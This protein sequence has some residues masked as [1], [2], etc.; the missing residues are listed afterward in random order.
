MQHSELDRHH[1]SIF[2]NLPSLENQTNQVDIILKP[3]N[4]RDIYKFRFSA[5]VNA[6]LYTADEV[7]LGT[8]HPIIFE[9]IIVKQLKETFPK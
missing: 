1:I 5:T 7:K 4:R 9:R 2:K 3:F 6:H 8:S